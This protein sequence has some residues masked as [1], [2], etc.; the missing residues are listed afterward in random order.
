MAES[1][2]ETVRLSRKL[3]K[4]LCHETS[5]AKKDDKKQDDVGV[6]FSRYCTTSVYRYIYIFI[7]QS[8]ANS[9]TVKTSI[10]FPFLNVKIITNDNK[11]RF[12]LKWYE[13]TL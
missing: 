6:F 13:I 1:S 8:A 7:L 10:F 9:F 11:K 2:F 12:K 4:R 5:A 3:D